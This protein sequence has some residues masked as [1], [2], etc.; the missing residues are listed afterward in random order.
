M[1]VSNWKI[2]DVNGTCSF[3]VKYWLRFLFL[4]YFFPLFF[5]YRFRIFV[6]I[7]RGKLSLFSFIYFFFNYPRRIDKVP[8][9]FQI[10]GKKLTAIPFALEL[11][12][13]TTVPSM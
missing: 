10:Y 13:I 2:S 3:F 12:M 4:F 8:V 9:N 5:P 1:L 6:L 7:I 11:K